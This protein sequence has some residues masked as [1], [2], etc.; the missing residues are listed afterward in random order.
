MASKGVAGRSPKGVGGASGEGAAAGRTPVTPERIMQQ[1]A[2]PWGGVMLA[3]AVKS[4][5]FT[6][7]EEGV[8]TVGAI[9]ERAGISR[10]GAQ[11]LLDGMAAAGLVVRQDGAY[12]N[13][14]DASTFLVQNKPTYM[15]ELPVIEVLD[16]LPQLA[17]FPEAVRTGDP[18]E[19]GGLPSAEFFSRLV[20]AIAPL[21][22]LPASLAAQELGVADAGP[23]EALDVGGGS[24]AWTVV[25][26][27]LNPQIRVTQID[28]P[29]VNRV[30][31]ELV[32]RE[33]IGD[34]F[35]VVDG[36]FHV[37]DLGWSRYDLAIYS[38]IAHMLGPAQNYAVFEKIRRA[39]KP[40]GTLVVADFV[41]EDDRRAHP[42]AL[43]FQA[44]MLMKTAEGACWRKADYTS[45]L[46]DAGF[47]E[48][49]FVSTPGPV[50]LIFAKPR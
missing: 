37:Q 41:L 11:V 28:L 33:G 42:I 39:L 29:A 23:L 36:D 26:G 14:P 3:T 49:R 12:R 25:L 1:V 38:N 34:R 43:L 19:T 22:F 4:G 6:L 45:W 13:A 50:T 17:R 31:R 10:R 21:A 35:Y 47:G 30:A 2:G 8:A 46:G 44:N 27:K 5:L 9:A 32:A 24:G 48:P 15:G 7:I 20:P 40:T 16:E 18:L